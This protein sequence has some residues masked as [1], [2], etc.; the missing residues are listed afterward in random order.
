MTVEMALPIAVTG[1]NSCIHI[2]IK[3]TQNYM[4]TEQGFV[5]KMPIHVESTQPAIPHNL[6]NQSYQLGAHMFKPINQ[7][8]KVFQISAMTVSS[9]FCFDKEALKHDF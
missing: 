7:P 1:W 2:V 9:I 6:L 5:S 4:K 3:K 8:W